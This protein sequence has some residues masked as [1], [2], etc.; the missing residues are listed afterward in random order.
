M[1][2]S[3]RMVCFGFLK[4]VEYASSRVLHEHGG[5]RWHNLWLEV[6]VEGSVRCFNVKGF[7]IETKWGLTCAFSCSVRQQV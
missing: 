1:P 4:D 3:V 5:V 2:F 7:N 6:G